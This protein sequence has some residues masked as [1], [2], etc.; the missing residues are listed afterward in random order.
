MGAAFAGSV[1]ETSSDPGEFGVGDEAAGGG[2]AVLEGV[3]A[4]ADFTEDDLGWHV[5]GGMEAVDRDGVCG[6]PSGE[7]EAGHD[8]GE[9]ALA[10]G[11][12]SVVV[13]LQHQIVEVDRM[14]ADGGDVDDPSRC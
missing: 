3:D 12:Y 9:L 14:L 1:V 7:F 10:V 13:A 5:G 8:L 2:Y 6:E 4:T 11:A